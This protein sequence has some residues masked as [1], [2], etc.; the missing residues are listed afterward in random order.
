MHYKKTLLL[1]IVSVFLMNCPFFALAGQLGDW[2]TLNYLNVRRFFNVGVLAYDTI[3]YT[4]GGFVYSTTPYPVEK[5]TINPDG[6]LS[7]WSIDSQTMKIAR[8]S[9]VSFY[10]N[11]FIYA[12]GGNDGINFNAQCTTA[13]RTKVNSDGSL[14]SWEYINPLLKGVIEGSLVLSPPYVYIIGGWNSTTEYSNEIMR[15]KIQSDGD[16]KEWT[17]S[18]SKLQIGRR[19]LTSILIDS[20]VYVVSGLGDVTTD[21]RNFEKA[22]INPDG[23]LSTFCICGSTKA[24][25]YSPALLF[26]GKYI[27]V[28]GGVSGG[29]F[30]Y[31]GERVLV[32]SDGTLGFPE[33]APP[34]VTETGGFGWV[35][36]STG[37]YVI[38]GDMTDVQFAPFLAP[39]CIQKKYWEVME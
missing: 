27:N 16:I 17:V 3:I 10:Y 15:G 8:M 31:R 13:E 38:G 28:I 30:N 23:E 37:G 9:P 1:L 2:T 33:L 5:A 34:L 4:L 11:G 39:T 25:H 26:D 29:Y 14:G 18:T 20:T 19:R 32:N 6:K 35:Q 22:V 36:A 21:T 24:L 7:N 12:F